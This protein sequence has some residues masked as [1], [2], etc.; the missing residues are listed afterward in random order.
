MNQFSNDDHVKPDLDEI[1][2]EIV[3]QIRAIQREYQK[4]IEPFVKELCRIRSLRPM[5]PVY[6]DLSK[7]PSCGG[8]AD[9]G[10]DRE[11]PPNVYACTRCTKKMGE[12]SALV[13]E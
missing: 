3:D 8:P 6:F 7:C 2:R 10:H 9:N 12:S 5:P 11:F 4:A 1:E 13:T